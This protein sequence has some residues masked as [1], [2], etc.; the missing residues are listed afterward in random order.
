MAVEVEVITRDDLARLPEYSASDLTGVV[1]GKRWR[2]DV[3]SVPRFRGV[4]VDSEWV[5]CEY[6]QAG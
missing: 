4:D 6:V 5:V 3:Q 1:V 2:R